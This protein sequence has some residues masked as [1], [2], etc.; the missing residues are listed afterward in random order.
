MTP[1]FQFVRTHAAYTRYVQEVDRG[2]ARFAD[3]DDT[4]SIL[5]RDALLSLY[6][7]LLTIGP[8]HG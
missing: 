4:A 7:K 2:I 8:E 5:V 1:A 3:R 6:E